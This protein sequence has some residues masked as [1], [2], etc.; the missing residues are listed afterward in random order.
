MTVFALCV[1]RLSLANLFLVGLIGLFLPALGNS[2]EE[3]T[4]YYYKLESSGLDKEF[5]TYYLKI[6]VTWEDEDLYTLAG[7]GDNLRGDTTPF[8]GV[9]VKRGNQYIV[10]LQSSLD[11]QWDV[12]YRGYYLLSNYIYLNENL[13]N[14][15]AIYGNQNVDLG[16]NDF[17]TGTI[18][19]ITKQEYDDFRG[20]IKHSVEI[21]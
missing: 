9:A 18:T 15:I 2:F 13:D 19:R 10:T 4:V 5:S 12:P 1:K 20:K 7:V 6:K 8:L 14:G 16:A 17:S 3:N 21:N 11:T